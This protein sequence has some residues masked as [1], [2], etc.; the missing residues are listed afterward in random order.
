VAVAVIY[1]VVAVRR[2]PVASSVDTATYARWADQLIALHFDYLAW[3]RAIEFTVPPLAYAAWVTVVALLKLALGDSWLNGILA[4][5]LAA[6][7]ASV[8]IVLGLVARI[9]ERRLVV[10]AA[11]VS[12]LVAFELFLWIPYCLSDVTFMFLAV[13][14]FAILLSGRR[15]AAIAIA[16]LALA[17]R[18]TALPLLVVVVFAILAVRLRAADAETRATAARRILMGIAAVTAIAVVLDAVLM[19]DPSRWP[20]PF[21]SSWIR[22]LAN[23][24]HQGQV[25]YGRPETYHAPPAGF[26]DYVWVD[27]D[28]LRSFFLFT[29]QDFSREH[30]LANVAFFV[31]VYAGW[32]VAMVAAARARADMSSRE[33]WATVLGTVFVVSF[34]VFHSLQQIDFDWRYRLPCLPV[35]VLLGAIGWRRM[36][37]QL[38][39]RPPTAAEAA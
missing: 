2:G 28:R 9:T 21:L 1:A 26:L 10:A 30:D 37:Q 16:V 34:C 23:E 17:Y 25:I 35:L 7:V 6:A 22:E 14:M 20:F 27:L 12:F 38:W 29:A 24:F 4:L 15:I 3:A 18:P 39:R 11:A 5:N 36:V 13:V 32:I 19:S 33:W 8:A 31:P